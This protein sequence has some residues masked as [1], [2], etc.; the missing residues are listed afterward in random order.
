VQAEEAVSDVNAGEVLV[1]TGDHL[2]VKCGGSTALRLLE[3]Q[4]EAK[5]RMS[6]RDFLNGTHLKVGD[7]FGD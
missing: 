3:I 5:R 6:V 2:I 7:R 1:A 4:P